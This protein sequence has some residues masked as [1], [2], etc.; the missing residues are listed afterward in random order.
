MAA[1]K[2]VVQTDVDPVLYEFIVKTAKSKGLT[3]KEA[4][5]EALRAWAVQEG[6]LS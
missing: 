4:A 5:R 6:N 1:A 2:R 3:L